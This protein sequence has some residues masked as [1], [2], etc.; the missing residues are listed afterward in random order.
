[1]DVVSSFAR[2]YGPKIH[3]FST[4]YF[5]LK[6]NIVKKEIISIK[7]SMWKD[8]ALYMLSE[9]YYIPDYFENYCKWDYISL[10]MI[11]FNSI[12]KNTYFII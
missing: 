12:N 5:S 10:N 4:F 2:I 9:R 7:I 8:A 6:S 11:Q 3:V 1:M